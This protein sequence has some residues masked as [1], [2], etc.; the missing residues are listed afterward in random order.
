MVS[1]YALIAAIRAKY[2]VIRLP[3]TASDTAIFVISLALG[4]RKVEEGNS[5]ILSLI[6]LHEFYL[7]IY[8]EKFFFLGGGWDGDFFALKG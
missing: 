7:F 4:E 1:P 6:I 2:I 5:D 3:I 8:F